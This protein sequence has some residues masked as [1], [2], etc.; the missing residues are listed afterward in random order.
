MPPPAVRLA[1]LLALGYAA[2][3]APASEGGVALQQAPLQADEPTRAGCLVGLA[4]CDVSITPGGSFRPGDSDL[5]SFVM[6]PKMTLGEIGGTEQCRTDLC[7]DLPTMPEGFLLVANEPEVESWPFPAFLYQNWIVVRF[8]DCPVRWPD[9]KAA[10][11]ASPID[12]HSILVRR[13]RVVTNGTAAPT[14]EACSANLGRNI[15]ASDVMLMG[16]DACDVPMLRIN[17]A[18]VSTATAMALWLY[19]NY[20]T[21]AIVV[22]GLSAQSADYDPFPNEWEYESKLL[23]AMEVSRRFQLINEGEQVTALSRASLLAQLDSGSKR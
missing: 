5:Q 11:H 14:V 8:G 9:V 10:N 16:G 3:A 15:T 17:G 2:H 1:Q 23:S 4:S 12:Q 18:R 22:A 7:G 13:E 20:P 19:D 21:V 6:D